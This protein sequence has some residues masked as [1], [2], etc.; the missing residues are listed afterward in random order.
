VKKNDI[1]ALMEEIERGLLEVHAEAKEKKE[2]LKKAQGG[3]GSS[4]SFPA[5]SKSE[6][7]EPPHQGA[8]FIWAPIIFRLNPTLAPPVVDPLAEFSHL[9]PFAV[10]N[11]V[12]AGSPSEKVLQSSHLSLDASITF[13]IA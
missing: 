3:V 6:S 7:N 12:A 8:C 13:D 4:P 11:S 10:V 1:E 2:A 5:P 9:Q